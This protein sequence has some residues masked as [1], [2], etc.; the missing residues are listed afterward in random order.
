MAY[1]LTQEQCRDFDYSSRC[2]WLLTNGIGGYAMGTASG[3]NTRRYHGLLVAAIKPPTSRMVLL[4]GIEAYA[5][6]GTLSYGLSTN[7]YVGAVHPTG[8]TILESFMV[9]SHAEWIWQAGTSRIRL[10]V[11]LT[12]GENAVSL[13]YSNLGTVP[14]QL[15]LRPLVEHKFYHD[16]FRFMDFYPDQVSFPDG[17]TVLTHQG[18]T[19]TLVHEGADRSPTT[20]WYY[21]FEHQRESERGLDP[22]DD[23]FCPCELRYHLDPGQ[24]ILLGATSSE[25]FKTTSFTDASEQT[26][27]IEDDLARSSRLFLVSGGGRETILAG[28]PWFTD[29]GRDTMISI[30]GICLAN[31]KLAAA[32]NILRGYAS[33]MHQGL[34]PN[35]FVDRGETPEY[36]T[37][38]ATLWFANAC[39]LSLQ[40]EEDKEFEAEV[41]AWLGD[42]IEWHVKGTQF[43]IG[44]DSKDGLLTQGEPGIQLTW[45][46]AK[47]GDWVVTPRHG[48]PVEING[49]WIN[50]LNIYLALIAKAGKSRPDL[51]ELLKKAT[52]SFEQ[53][54]WREIDGFYLDT[55]DPDDVSLRPNQ[56]IAMSLPYTPCHAEHAAR[57]LGEIRAQLLTPAGLRTLSPSD[58]A[59]HGRFEGPLSDRDAAYHQGTAWPWLIGSYIA[60]SLRFVGNADHCREALNFVA[61]RLM[62]CGLGGIAEVYDGDEPQYAGGC[63]WQAWSVAETLRAYKLLASFKK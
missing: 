23:E 34:I 56:L 7:Q 40:E 38:D 26:P 8:Y 14:I 20:G 22:L 4:A 61:D 28:Y 10:R 36:N 32:K 55:V 29:W 3:A 18:V 45:M 63:P 5:S 60:A 19:L 41:T 49:L 51:S 33:Q 17:K 53:K 9:D 35:R 11:A 43:G 27:S 6:V 48:K 58:P 25:E 42:V 2:E 39:H 47:V 50:L 15:T 54:F 31:G 16:N 1:R 59:Y 46:D 57:A 24:S 52:A 44:V 21:R 30:P 62:D 13:E 37:V 12:E